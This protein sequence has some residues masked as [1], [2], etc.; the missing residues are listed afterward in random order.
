M[1]SEVPPTPGAAP[2]R[3]RDELFP[4]VTIAP[5]LAYGSAP[6]L[7]GRPVTLRLD[8]YQPA[9]DTA[10]DRAA[11]VWVHGGGFVGGGKGD[12]RPQVEAFARRGFVVVS[13][14]YRLLSNGCS[15]STLGTECTNAAAAAIADGKAAVRWLRSQAVDLGLDPGRITIA[16]FSAGAIVATGVGVLGEDPGASGNPGQPS[17]V[18]AFISVAGGLPDGQ[19][20]DASDAPGYLFSGSADD[21]VPHQWS[22]DTA[23]ALQAAGVPAVLH[24]TPGGGHDLPDLGYLV[25][26]SSAFLYRELDLGTPGTPATPVTTTTTIAPATTTPSRAP[27]PALPAA[28]GAAVGATPIG[29]APAYT[30]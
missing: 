16:G 3:Y 27:A 18:A 25:Q 6:D 15:G 10:R 9:G 20:V 4:T 7:Q 19:G 23:E 17:D 30:G 12:E 1:P 26:Q 14:D 24:T 2:L 11:I 28:P 13:I 8:L 5:D 29:A 21:V 22:V